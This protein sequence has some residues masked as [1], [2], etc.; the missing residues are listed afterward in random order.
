MAHEQKRP[1]ASTYVK[2]DEKYFDLLYKGRPN[3]KKQ[4]MAQHVC[5][6]C[7]KQTFAKL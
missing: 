7:E 6:M 1:D 5:H 4:W 2:V 3:E